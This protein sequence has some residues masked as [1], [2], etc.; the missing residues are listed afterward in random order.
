MGIHYMDLE[1]EYASSRLDLFNAKLS[2]NDFYQPEFDNL[3]MQ[4]LTGAE[5]GGGPNA[6]G[7]NV[8]SLGWQPRY[9]EYKSCVNVCH[10]PFAKYGS[11]GKWGPLSYWAS[12]R[13]LTS[14][15]PKLLNKIYPNV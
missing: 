5:F 3:G 9:A 11:A 7:S 13:Q 15:D 10:G 12:C 6:F 1:P 2:Q 8:Q 14:F 4:P